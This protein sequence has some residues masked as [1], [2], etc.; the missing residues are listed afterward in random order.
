MK[1]R[2]VKLLPVIVLSGVL[3]ACTIKPVLH[4]ASEQS[5]Y[6]WQQRLPQLSAID[7]WAF[8]GRVVIKSDA[9]GW[10]GGIVWQQTQ[11]NYRIDFLTPVGQ[12]VMQIQGGSGGVVL[13]LSDGSQY[14]A[15]DAESLLYERLGWGLP[16]KTLVSW[17]KGMPARQVCHSASIDEQGRVTRLQQSDWD[18]DYKRYVETGST[19]LPNKIFMSR[20]DINIRLVIANWVL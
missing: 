15:E 2:F 6:N 7:S 10:N 18:I 1:S 9:E 19:A 4:S 5:L 13:R 8:R 14:Q 12:N 16:V 20:D 17:V 11:G 3:A